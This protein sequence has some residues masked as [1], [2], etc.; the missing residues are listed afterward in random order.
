VG[1]TLF[2]TANDGT[3]G[4]ELWKSDGTGAGTM[5]VKD[6]NPGGASSSPQALTEPI[7][8]IF[9]TADDGTNGRE[10]WKS[11]GTE[12]GTMLLKDIN[13]GDASSDPRALSVWC[14]TDQCD[15][16]LTLFFSA[17]D[18]TTGV[19]LWKSDES[20]PTPSPSPSP[21]TAASPTILVVGPGGG[22]APRVKIFDR[23][24][25]KPSLSFDAFGRRFRGG[26]RVAAGDVN[27]DGFPDIIAGAGPGGGPRVKVFDGMNGGELRSFFAYDRKFQGGVFVAGGDVTGDGVA[28]IITGPGEGG[29]P[30]VNVFDGVNGE[31]LQS[32]LPFSRSFRGGVRVAAGDVNGDGVADIITGPGEGSKSRVSAF[33]GKDLSLL[34]SF[35]AYARQFTGGVYVAAGDVDGDGLDDIITGPGPGMASQVR[36]FTIFDRWGN[37]LAYDAKFKGGVYVAVGDVNGD[38]LDDIITAP[39]AGGSPRV[40]AFNAEDQSL[41]ESFLV[42]DRSFKGGVFVAF[43]G[44]VTLVR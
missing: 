38:G 12:L 14:V 31:K 5:L 27:G 33:D 44:I 20:T 10:L 28:D 25:A 42:Y 22:M 7:D 30:R 15:D 4:V 8:K 3:T 40:K 24:G 13:P 18:G 35:L 34:G 6:I 9:F 43:K 36:I 11:N 37:L 32:F 16:T 23:W 26:V 17:N 29:K 21:T 19:E 41:L 1:G 2:F 39:G